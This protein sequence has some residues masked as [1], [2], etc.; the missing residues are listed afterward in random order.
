MH[1]FD[2]GIVLG[3]IFPLVWMIGSIHMWLCIAGAFIND[4]D[5][6]RPPSYI[7]DLDEMMDFG[8]DDDLDFGVIMLFQVITFSLGAAGLLVSIMA[9]P[10]IYPVISIMIY[11][12]YKRNQKRKGEQR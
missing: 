10:F 4:E 11:A 9:W 1:Y 3:F 6:W 12:Y 5:K 2:I 8:M 7:N